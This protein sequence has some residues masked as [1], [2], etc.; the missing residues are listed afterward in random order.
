MVRER[1]HSAWTQMCH[2]IPV[3]IW[4]ANYLGPESVFCPL[5]SQWETPR[6]YP[7]VG[8]AV[9]W[10]V[11]CC[12]RRDSALTTTRAKVLANRMAIRVWKQHLEINR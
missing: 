5:I 7:P 2:G 10:Y 6:A 1:C 4:R 12:G 3:R 11:S 9:V 8:P